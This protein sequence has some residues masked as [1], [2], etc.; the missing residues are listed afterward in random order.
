LGHAIGHQPAPEYSFNPS[1][2]QI[3]EVVDV[4]RIAHLKSLP[5]ATTGQMP[6]C[7]IA[8]WYPIQN[9]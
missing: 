8:R 5:V 1:N 9:A 7:K 2:D 3:T 6:V 4:Q